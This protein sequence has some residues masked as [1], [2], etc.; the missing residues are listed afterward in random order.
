MAIVL[1][2]S[3]IPFFFGFRL[4]ASSFDFDYLYILEFDPSS[5]IPPSLR[6]SVRNAFARLDCEEL[7]TFCSLKDLLETSTFDHDKIFITRW[8]IDNDRKNLAKKLTPLRTRKSSK[9]RQPPSSPNSRG[10][11]EGFLSLYK[12]DSLYKGF[13]V[14]EGFSLCTITYVVKSFQTNFMILPLGFLDSH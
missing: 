8:Q 9:W 4:E 14:Q 10:V 1:V 5:S 6:P 3:R 12:R 2:S 7:V 11:R 13:S